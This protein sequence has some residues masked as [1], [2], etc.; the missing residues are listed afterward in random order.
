MVLLDSNII[1]ETL[2]P[3][4]DAQVTHWM[5]KQTALAVSVI[6]LDEVLY[7]LQRK[8]MMAGLA[9]FEH[10]LKIAEIIVLDESMARTAASLRS[11]FSQQGITRSQQDMQ[12]AATAIARECTLATRNTKDFAGC[13]LRLVNPFSDTPETKNS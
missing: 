5:A 12:I 2:K 1:S 6:S 4:P 11:D 10:L 7:G 8:R 3:F 9:R 13:S